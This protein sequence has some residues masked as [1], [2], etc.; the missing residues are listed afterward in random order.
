MK[1]NSKLKIFGLITIASIS[2]FA[3]SLTA[4]SSNKLATNISNKIYSIQYKN[5]NSTILSKT[6]SEWQNEFENKNYTDFIDG[7]NQIDDQ[8]KNSNFIINEY[9]IGNIYT[10]KTES[11]SPIFINAIATFKNNN[12]ILEIYL[13]NLFIFPPSNIA[14]PNLELVENPIT[15]NQSSL[16]IIYNTDPTLVLSSQ[17]M[18]CL[19]SV[20]PSGTTYIPNS[21]Y[22]LK[23]KKFISETT[24]QIVYSINNQYL[25]MID[26]EKFPDIVFNIIVSE[27]INKIFKNSFILNNDDVL[28]FF[29]SNNSETILKMSQIDIFNCLNNYVNSLG[30]IEQ[31]SNCIDYSNNEIYNF[32]IINE[33]INNSILIKFSSNP[34]NPNSTINFYSFKLYL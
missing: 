2:L 20:A 21:I 29:N 32:L 27:N 12:E 4:C 34:D 19:N 24:Y 13:N 6:V 7:I 1:K 8:Y 22:Y 14:H 28:K 25:P 15:I 16:P 30:N 9:T 5:L 23:S 18:S 3:I 31:I 33:P 11:D 10:V 17:W 26:K